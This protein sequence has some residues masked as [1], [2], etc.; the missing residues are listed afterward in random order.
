MN[1]SYQLPRRIGTERKAS[2]DMSHDGSHFARPT[3][4]FSSVVFPLAPTPAFYPIACGSHRDAYAFLIPSD[5]RRFA[6]LLIS[7]IRRGTFG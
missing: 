2:F 7:R 1:G 4:A 5:A 6:S 3:A